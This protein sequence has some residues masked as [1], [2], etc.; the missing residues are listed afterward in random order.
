MKNRLLLIIV[1]VL[2][3][4][5]GVSTASAD[6]PVEGRA[7]RAELRFLEGMVDHH[8][9]AL[10][11]ARDCLE[12]ASAEA[13]KTL[14][15]NIITAQS[16]EIETMRGWLLDW[17]NVDYEPVAMADMMADGGMDMGHGGMGGRPHT[18]PPMMMGMMAGL[19]RLK[20]LDYDIAW[21]EAMI[22]HHDDALH[23][24]ERVLTRAEHP[25]LRELAEA[26][27]SAQTAEI[28]IMEQLIVELSG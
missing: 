5:I 24:S 17:Y 22:D 18:D 2:M 10:D 16:A 1:V 8:Q 28:E 4:A 7:G 13:L 6:E 3:L 20:G 23:M 14:C 19:N 26:I 21:L 9:M 12:K 15:Q 25:E 27:I 11:M